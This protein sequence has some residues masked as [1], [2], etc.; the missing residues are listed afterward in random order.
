M[1]KFKKG[2]I[3]AAG[4]DLAYIYKIVEI[5]DDILEV[6]ILSNGVNQHDK[7]RWTNT[8]CSFDRLLT[9]AETILYA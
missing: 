5:K 4:L 9:K 8:T 3:Y 7:L 1:S 6:E 2:Q